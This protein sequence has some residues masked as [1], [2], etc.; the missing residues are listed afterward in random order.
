VSQA[1]QLFAGVST[2]VPV[3]LA[4]SQYLRKKTTCNYLTKKG[5]NAITIGDAFGPFF[6]RADTR[7][8]RCF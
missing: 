2:Y 3:V 5:P 6:D 4:P 8:A 1:S 7:S